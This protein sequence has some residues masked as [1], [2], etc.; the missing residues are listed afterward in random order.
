VLYGSYRLAEHLGVRFYLHGDVIPDRKIG[1][2]LPDLSESGKPL[3]DIRGIVP[4]HDFPEGPDWWN[5]DDYLAYISQLAKMRMNF[6]GLHCYPEGHP[7]AEPAV[8]IGLPDDSD[9]RGR[10]R[11]S[12]PSS[13]ANT[14]RPNPW[15]Y[16]AT[17]TSDFSAGA[18]LLFPDD[19]YG[20]AVMHGVMPLPATPE[21]C[22]QLFN[23][24]ADLFRMAFAHARSLGVKTCIGTET[25]LSVPGLVQE[26]LKQRGE[27]YRD[28]AVVRELY[29]GMFRRIGRACPVD[30]YWL[31][32]PEGWTWGEGKPDQFQAT[33]TDIRTAL[34]ALKAAG[35]PFTLATCGWVLGPAH[36]RAALSKVLPKGCPMSCISRQVGH[37]ALER[38]F[39]EITGRPKWAIPWMENDPNMV[40]PQ[41]WVGRM[42]Y[43][44]ADALRLGCTGLLGIHWR[45]KIM[46]PNVSALAGAAW[47]QSWTPKDFDTSPLV[48]PRRVGGGEKPKAQEADSGDD[49]N[50][51]PGP[52]R[53]MPAEDFYVDFARTSFGENVAEAVGRILAKIDGA[54]YGTGLPSPSDWLGGPGGIS[55]HKAPWSQVEAQHFGFLHDLETLRAK[56]EGAGNLQRFDYWLN[57]YRYMAAMTEAGCVRARLDQAMADMDAEKDTVKQKE[58]AAQ[59]LLLRIQL[60]RVWERI[61]CLQVAA[62]DTPG[63]L[64]TIANLEQHGR[65]QLLEAHDAALIKTLGAPL[66]AEAQ[67]SKAY[68]G[69]RRIIVPTVRT[70]VAEGEAMKLTV[71]ALNARPVKRGALFWR[72]LGKGAFQRVALSHLARAVYVAILPPAVEDIE[73]H[74]LVETDDGKSLVWPATAPILDQTVVVLPKQ[75]A[76]R[77]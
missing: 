73:Y 2:T 77:L 29:L 15:N 59:A 70:H 35:D 31:W 75:Q 68:L 60:A 54:G 37:A 48:Q 45:T 64:G 20:P 57:T 25:P 66:P 19:L 13:W 42:R 58:L 28:P 46:A 21:H 36:D 40:A 71:I 26:R 32:T 33:A 49:K 14:Q 51:D 4:F 55:V 6:I 53:T 23:N 65:K 38:G 30:Y 52:N 76:E 56:V 1:S 3:F 16:A 7:F 61:L 5:R 10:V 12:Y 22:N 69:P 17:K 72:P 62:A 8:W 34:E 27:D 39:A 47:D 67:P 41:P 44:A 43:D 50:T 74:I 24:V 9:E 11:F 63:E 18:S